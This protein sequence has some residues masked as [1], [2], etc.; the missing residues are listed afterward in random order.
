MIEGIISPLE[1]QFNNMF[2]P[3]GVGI[4]QPDQRRSDQR[5]K[6]PQVACP[7]CRPDYLPKKLTA[8]SYQPSAILEKQNADG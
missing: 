3:G 7:E 4:P 1:R 5:L 8:C 2:Y 6:A